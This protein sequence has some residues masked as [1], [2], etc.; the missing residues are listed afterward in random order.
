[1]KKIINPWLD[2][3]K[4]GYN[5]FGCAPCNP[6]GLKMEFY[7]DGDE[8]VSFWN[9]SD[10]YQGWLHTLHGGIQSAIMDEIAAWVMARKLQR[11]GMTTNLDIKFKKPV[12]TGP[13]VRIEVRAHIKE[14]KRNFAFMS[15]RIIYQGEVCSEAEM[16]YYCFSPEKSASAFYFKGCE[17]EDDGSS[18]E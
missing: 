17:V 15:A 2:L 9:S 3:V 4:D 12:P 10:N 16:T 14:M 5:C 11:A 18:G 1:M 6:F 7:E 8:I 13:D